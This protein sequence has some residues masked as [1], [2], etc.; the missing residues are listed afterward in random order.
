MAD[1]QDKLDLQQAIAD[2][3]K[4]QLAISRQNN[5]EI[6][7]ILDN[8][9][10][11]V[12]QRRA[13]LKL[14]RDTNKELGK[15]ASLSEGLNDTFRESDKIQKDIDNSIAVRARLT[16]EQKQAEAQGN[17]DL[18]AAIQKKAKSIDANIGRLKQEKGISDEINKSFGIGEGLLQGVN[19]LTKGKLADMGKVINATRQ[20]IGQEV[21][22]AKAAGKS[23][24]AVKGAGIAAKNF[25]KSLLKGKN[26]FLLLLEAAIQ[27]SKEINRFQ[28]ELGVSYSSALALRNEFTL[29]AAKSGDIFVNSKKLQEAFFNLKESV[30][31]FFDTSSKA[32]ETFLNLNKRIG[33][34]ARE[35]GKLTLLSRLQGKNTEKITS[36]FFKIANSSAKTVGTTATAKDILIE[37]ATAST[38]L[39]AALSATPDA[40]IKAAAAA[41]AFGTELRTLESIQKGLL[42]F[43]QSI[44]A[45]LEAELLTGRQLNLEKARLFALNN[46]IEGLQSE[47]VRQNITLSSFNDMN[48]LQQ[49]AIAKAIG[50][51]RDTLGDA[52]MKQELQ[53]MT[54]DEIRE[55]FGDQTYE[56]QKALAAQDKV[57]AMMEQFTAILADIGVVLAPIL[58]LTMAVLQLIRPLLQ[59]IGGIASLLGSAVG[60]LV[61][62]TGIDK[63]NSSMDGG[64]ANLTTIN[65]GILFN[66][67]DKFSLVASTS[68]GALGQ[69][70]AN[71][72]GMSRSDMDYLGGIINNKKVEFDPYAAAGPSAM[73]ATDAR[74]ENST[75][76]F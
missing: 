50:M 75:I 9:Q 11:N 59:L 43:E 76:R 30:G 3:L 28:K 17:T 63:L 45:E 15:N 58:D 74:R 62:L 68:E 67:E 16:V 23:F 21:L 38:G 36:D 32:S 54:L 64:F 42:Q 73:A 1:P 66:P 52:L 39:Q 22:K 34:G 47:L 13:I 37:A 70:T 4:E 53:S 61:K 48:V 41:K 57:N 6:R 60:G 29:A 65:D 27:A 51:S 71:M 49:E 7:D 26:I 56:Q 40:L 55:K 12:D 33:I 10:L 14:I 72:S 44:S 25:G 8:T 24:S 18:A 35:A 5:D 46:D 31:F 20:Q 69:A 2:V 19:K